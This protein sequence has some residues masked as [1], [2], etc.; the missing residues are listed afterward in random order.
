MLKRLLVARLARNSGPMRAGSKFNA[1]KRMVRPRPTPAN[2]GHF[3]QYL[4]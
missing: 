2:S 3:Q 4:E 1:T